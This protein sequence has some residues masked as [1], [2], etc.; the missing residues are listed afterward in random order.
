MPQTDNDKTT[1][2]DEVAFSELQIGQSD[3]KKEP[4]EVTNSLI[5]PPPLMETQGD[6]TWNTGREELLEAEKRL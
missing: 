3:P 1:D 2:I 4:V 6:M 5:P